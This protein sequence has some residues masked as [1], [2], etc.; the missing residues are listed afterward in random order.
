MY[1]TEVISMANKTIDIET[2]PGVFSN[3]FKRNFFEF[4]DKEIFTNELLSAAFQVAYDRKDKVKKY[5]QIQPDLSEYSV[6]I[7]SSR[8]DFPHFEIC[9]G[10]L[11]FNGETFVSF[12]AFFSKDE[13]E[14]RKKLLKALLVEFM[15]KKAIPAIQACFKDIGH[16]TSFIPHYG[17]HGASE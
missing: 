11:N 5:S 1:V 16:V 6:R 9:V 7:S 2:I 4:I 8:K 10:R 15:D 3:I 13:D 12:Q 14:K 17:V